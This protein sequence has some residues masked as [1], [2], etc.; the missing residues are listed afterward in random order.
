MS[1]LEEI[2]KTIDELREHLHHLAETRDLSD[3]EVIAASQMLD[4]I[5]NEYQRQM[6]NKAAHR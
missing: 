6:K 5:L 2:L 1:K 4:V 3:P